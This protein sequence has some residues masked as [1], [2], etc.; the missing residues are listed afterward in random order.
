MRRIGMIV[1]LAAVWLEMSATTGSAQ[2]FPSRYRYHSSY[3]VDAYDAAVGLNALNNANNAYRDRAQNYQAWRQQPSPQQ[4]GAI[5]GTM[6]ADAQGRSQ[7]I[8]GQQQANRDWW[9]QTQQQQAAQR[10]GEVAQQPY[11]SLA[12]PPP[13]RA[14]Q[15]QDQVD[16]AALQR[17]YEAAQRE[18]Y[19]TRRRYEL[20]QF[21]PGFESAS[22]AAPPV[23]TDIIKWSPVLQAPQFAEQ[24][25]RIEAPYR[26]GAKGLSTPTAKDYQDMIAAT[27]QMKLILKN[28][29]TEI[30]AQDYLNAAA[31]LDQL[32]A[33]ARGRLEKASPKK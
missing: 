28:M 15:P 31:F 9:F 6:D 32:A 19:Q 5:R 30:S 25:A 27:G 17:Q 16:Q 2:M 29:A 18:R 7:A 3:D 1:L 21:A 13:P 10:Q 20:A 8:I 11:Q 22:P 12:V 14:M 4:T 24:R 26:R 33:E 23:A